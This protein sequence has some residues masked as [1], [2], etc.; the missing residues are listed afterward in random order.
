MCAEIFIDI[1]LNTFYNNNLRNRFPFLGACCGE[2]KERLRR[3]LQINVVYSSY[4]PHPRYGQLVR[5]FF[6]QRLMAK[7]HTAKAVS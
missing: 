6:W 1:S 4:M 7:L 5:N 2:R 3:S